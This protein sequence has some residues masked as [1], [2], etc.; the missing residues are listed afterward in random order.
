MAD[1]L[2]ILKKVRINYPHL[3]EPTDY[4]GDGNFKYKALFIVDKASDSGKRL[5]AEFDRVAKE[6]WKDK[7]AKVIEKI[8]G[9]AQKIALRDGDKEDNDEYAGHW[10]L[11]V[12]N[13][14]R[15]TVKDRDN[16]PLSEKDNRPESGDVVNAKVQIYT[17]TKRGDAIYGQLYGVQFVESGPGFSGGINVKDVD[18]DDLDTSDEDLA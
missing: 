10:L 13:K 17:M 7:G 18:F 5:R 14:K 11:S 3:F 12:S 8:W 16:S 4:E 9:N 2:F 15:P 6:Q 1:D